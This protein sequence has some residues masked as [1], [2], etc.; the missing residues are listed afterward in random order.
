MVEGAI[1][2]SYETFHSPHLVARAHPYAYYG[3]LLGGLVIIAVAL[4]YLFFLTEIGVLLVTGVL[5]I[6]LAFFMYGFVVRDRI[7]DLQSEKRKGV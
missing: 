7:R 3:S 2:A 4:V 1:L 6:L 5:L